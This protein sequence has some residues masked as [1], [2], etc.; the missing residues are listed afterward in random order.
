MGSMR[1][2]LP[3]S[4]GPTD[5]NRGSPGGESIVSY[6]LLRDGTYPVNGHGADGLPARLGV[7]H[8]SAWPEGDAAPG[9]SGARD[10]AVVLDRWAETGAVVRVRRIGPQAGNA[11]LVCELL[12]LLHIQLQC[13]ARQ[14]TV[15]GAVAVGRLRVGGNGADGLSGPAL[16]KARAMVRDRVVFPLIAVEEEVFGRLR[17][18]ESLWAPDHPLRSEM[19]V[20]EEM[21]TADDAG[22]HYIDYLRAGLGDFDYDFDRYADFLGRHR[23]FVASGLSDTSLLHDSRTYRWL[24]RYHNARID[25]DISPSAGEGFASECGLAMARALVPL[26]IP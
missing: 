24:K 2:S 4:A 10:L 15:R 6:L 14:M 21:M 18:D 11:P 13:L 9:G 20:I 12:D 19:D 5:G 23:R 16:S 25:A 8:C 17:C 3:L 26:R 1:E 7:F 22:V